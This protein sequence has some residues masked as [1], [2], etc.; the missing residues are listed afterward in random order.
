MAASLFSKANNPNPWANGLANI[1]L[2]VSKVLTGRSFQ[3]VL[4]WQDYR[5]FLLEERIFCTLL[6][7][8]CHLSVCS[9]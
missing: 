6:L 7:Q 3:S 9:R 2:R 4:L 5:D 8:G 1:L